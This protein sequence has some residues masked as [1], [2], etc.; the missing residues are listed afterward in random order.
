MEEKYIQ[1]KLAVYV[2]HVVVSIVVN[3]L[4]ISVSSSGRIWR[5][6]RSF[7]FPM[8]LF[9]AGGIAL[10]VL[11]CALSSIFLISYNYSQ[12]KFFS[13]IHTKYLM[14]KRL[15]HYLYMFGKKC[16]RT[17]KDA[18][19]YTRYTH[20]KL[21]SWWWVG[22]KICKCSTCSA[23]ANGNLTNFSVWWPG[24]QIKTWK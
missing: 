4:T 11:H 1:N 21:W 13:I 8:I 22:S 6:A 24:Y 18:T 3:Q 9:T 14:P 19:I 2:C 12:W 20:I 17:A 15:T 23:C 16:W 10:L 7:G 5:I